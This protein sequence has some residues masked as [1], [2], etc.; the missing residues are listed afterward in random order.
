MKSK[1]LEKLTNNIVVLRFFARAPSRIQR[2]V[3]IC[4]V[5]YSCKKFIIQGGL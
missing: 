4:D 3:K 2:I 5:N 1:A